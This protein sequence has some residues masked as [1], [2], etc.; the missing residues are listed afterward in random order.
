MLHS[1]GVI[2]NRIDQLQQ[3]LAA[4][5]Q[6]STE[7]RRN[8]AET[9]HQQKELARF[10]TRLDAI[11]TGSA[12]RG[13]AGAHVLEAILEHLPPSVTAFNPTI[14]SRMIEFV[15]RLLNG[16]HVPIHSKWVGIRQLEQREEAPSE[17]TRQE[18]EQL[19][20]RRIEEVTA[21]RD[22]NLALGLAIVAVPDAAYR[23]I[24]RLPTRAG[25]GRHRHRLQ[26]GHPPIPCP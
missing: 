15:F 2:G 6:V 14:R 9:C 26:R 16:K 13:A 8:D 7:L 22:P 17:R 20:A 18:C 25:K 24:Q 21:Y 23:W 12:P 11:L 19:L 10:V 4:T 5:H 3:A 1:Q